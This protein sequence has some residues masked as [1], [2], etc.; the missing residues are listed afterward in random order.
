MIGFAFYF[1]LG[2]NLVEDL[3]DVQAATICMYD[4]PNTTCYTP[5]QGKI[6]PLQGKICTTNQGK[7]AKVNKPSANLN[8][9]QNGAPETVKF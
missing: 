9:P 5:L 2:G 6:T 8:R 4:C 7:Q 1:I 3:C